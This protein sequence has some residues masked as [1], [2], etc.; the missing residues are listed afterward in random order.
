M[1]PSNSLGG[2]PV[3]ELCKRESPRFTSHHL[4]PRSRGGRLGPRARLCPTCHRQLHAMFSEATLAKEL[5]SIET[6]RAN[7]EVANYLRWARH[8]KGPTSFRVRRAKNRR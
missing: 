6:L 2:P 7:I 1:A 5:N 8:Q 4:V 3:C